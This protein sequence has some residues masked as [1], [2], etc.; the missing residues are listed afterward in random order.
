M[1][2]HDAQGNAVTGATAE[3]LARYEQAA[4]QLRCYTGDPLAEAE[5]AIAASPAMPMAQALKA[6]LLLLG[7]EP[8][9]LAP[10]RAAWLAGSRLHADRRESAHLCAIGL[11][12]DGH[13]HDAARALEDLSI[14]YPCDALAL[15]AGHQLDFFTGNARMLRDRIARALPD[16]DERVPGYHA[17]LG[18][19][20]FG[21]EETGAY[22]QAEAQGR[23][24]LDLERHDGWAQH[25]VVHVMEMQGRHADGIAWMRADPDAWSRDSF[26]AVHNW[27]HL[28]MFHLDLGQTGEVLALL[29]GP[30]DGRGSTTVLE[31][32]DA[33]AM[34]W[35][36]H[37]RGVAL[38]ARWA[39]L[40]DRWEPF[41]AAG[42]Y[43]FNDVH[44]MMAFV[45]A[46]RRSAAQSLL[47]AQQAAMRADGD[48]AE[49]TRAVGHPAAQALQAFGEGDY[50]G[51]M[52]RLRPLRGIAQ[53]FGGS[54]AQRDLFDL[55]LIES[56]LRAGARGLAGALIA[57]RAALRPGSPQVREF[58]NRLAVGT[59]ARRV[60]FS[61][62]T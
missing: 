41:A 21:L 55:T 15:Q 27:W 30:I 39:A 50:A 7:T 38:G 34:L 10:A 13:W 1:S 9:G 20:A 54:H 5:A 17:L 31:L 52:R 45:G 2:R 19:H 3:G 46:G 4:Q 6:W 28:A 37:L 18:M 22:A 53:R 14:E 49:F 11:L 60:E 36:L 43:A 57:E 12:L 8:G 26:L 24:A 51:C 56:A 47:Q 35:R 29:D 62:S 33:S 44:A 58:R 59:P 40:A 25:A 16:W 42:N 32:I 48:N 23:R 61:P